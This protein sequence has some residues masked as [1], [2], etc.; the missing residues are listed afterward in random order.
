MKTQRKI[1]SI[2]SVLCVFILIIAG[3][4]ASRSDYQ[5]GYDAGAGDIVKDQYWIIQNRQK[6]I[7]KSDYKVRYYQFNAPKNVDG[8]NYVP[9]KITVR[10]I[11]I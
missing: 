5:K 11:D 3:G 1:L 7:K 8:V 2:I 6:E 10:S 9:H 4:C